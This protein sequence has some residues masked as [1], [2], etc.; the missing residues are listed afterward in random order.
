MCA[1][2]LL[3]PGL[4]PVS[5]S[6]RSGRVFVP[7]RLERWERQKTESFQ[8]TCIHAS[9]RHGT[10]S[11][12]SFFA[13][14]KG[15]MGSNIFPQKCDTSRVR[16][17]RAGFSGCAD[18]CETQSG[19]W[20]LPAPEKAGPLSGDRRTDLGGVDSHERLIMRHLG[21]MK[22]KRLAHFTSTP[23]T[24]APTSHSGGSR[25]SRRLAAR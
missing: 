10:S 6:P 14:Q 4:V 3:L 5:A 25:G 15:P 19:Q 20:A 1:R 24:R 9:T 2:N 16:L 13:R 12:C 17:N 8:L 7:A 22:E 23:E 11:R 18:S 21:R